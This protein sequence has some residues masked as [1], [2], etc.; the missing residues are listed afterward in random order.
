MLRNGWKNQQNNHYFHC[1][2]LSPRIMKFSKSH[3][4]HVD[5]NT[6]VSSVAYKAALEDTVVANL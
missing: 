3:T 4:D 6:L 2:M 1:F 5:I